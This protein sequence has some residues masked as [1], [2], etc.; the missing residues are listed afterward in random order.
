MTTLR[1][2]TGFFSA[3]LCLLMAACTGLGDD[4][5]P[6][7][8]SA[9]AYDP[10]SRKLTWTASGDDGD[11]GRGALADI[12]AVFDPLDVDQGSFKPENLGETV[13]FS[14]PPGAGFA[15]TPREFLVPRLSL[16][17]PPFVMLAQRDEV[18]NVGP[19]VIPASTASN[20]DDS[21][22][23]DLI[24][25]ACG[26]TDLTGP[27]SFA[28]GEMNGLTGEDLAVGDPSNNRVLVFY[29]EQLRPFDLL[30]KDRFCEPDAILDGSIIGA[31]FGT[32]VAVGDVDG[33]RADELFVSAPEFDRNDGL[34]QRG[35]IFVFRM[36]GAVART[37]DFFTVNTGP[38]EGFIAQVKTVEPPYVRL[39]RRFTESIASNREQQWSYYGSP[40]LLSGTDA[41]S[42]SDSL[43]HVVNDRLLD[44]VEQNW[45]FAITTGPNAGFA[46]RIRLIDDVVADV[47]RIVECDDKVRTS[48]T[49]S[50]A[51]GQGWA[52]YPEA[53]KGRTFTSV[54][55]NPFVVM[56]GIQNQLRM[57]ALDGSAGTEFP[58]LTIVGPPATTGTLPFGFGGAMTASG[59]LNGDGYGDLV[60]GVPGLDTV[61]WA[62]RDVPMEERGGVLVFL[63]DPKFTGLTGTVPYSVSGG[64]RDLSKL[65]AKPEIT[66]LGS[67]A[68]DRLG[69]A[70]SAARRLSENGATPAAED[71]QVP[72]FAL[73]MGAPGAD[74]DA[75]TDAGKVYAFTVDRLMTGHDWRAP[76]ALSDT[77]YNFSD[78]D[79]SGG[80]VESDQ[81]HFE[82]WGAEESEELGGSLELRGDFNLD[83]V[84]DLAVY[85]SG[86]QGE[87]RIYLFM[88]SPYYSDPPSGYSVS[89]STTGGSTSYPVQTINA[90]NVDVNRRVD[91]DGDGRLEDFEDRCVYCILDLSQPSQFG[92]PQVTLL[93]G[94]AA[95]IQPDI[96]AGDF[97]PDGM[98]EIAFRAS[99]AS[100]DIQVV[101]NG[102]VAGLAPRVVPAGADTCEML[103]VIQALQRYE[104]PEDVRDAVR[105]AIDSPGCDLPARHRNWIVGRPLPQGGTSAGLDGNSGGL[106]AVVRNPDDGTVQ[107][108]LEPL[109][110]APSEF[111]RLAE[112]EPSSENENT[113]R[114][115]VVEEPDEYREFWGPVLATG[116]PSGSGYFTGT[117]SGFHAG[118]DLNGDGQPDFVFAADGDLEPL[119]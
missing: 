13:V 12:R 92:L 98:D 79:G 114:V 78:P 111:I 70:L 68:G 26:F 117:V 17:R 82:I 63:G 56:G 90:G 31:G 23:T 55:G 89:G 4:T 15:G 30:P 115:K 5:A 14:N 41:V 108:M 16:G 112:A 58:S 22:F 72:Y 44:G 3:A 93:G 66:F 38:Q 95:V 76:G 46:C 39:D 1:R 77:V 71:P 8:V 116:R 110:L 61:V 81:G 75:L 18:G 37:G 65:A 80:I 7:P 43:R 45:L 49:V 59:D 94:P 53:T 19:F 64:F 21:F 101:L 11:T 36:K 48:T 47:K 84:N 69:T 88:A 50:A 73:A 33:D 24:Q 105:S 107:V 87:G 86:P 83:S 67:G 103:S 10:V 85:A 104:Q 20:S 52:I 118:A 34:G 119:H 102:N 6:G 9:P 40:P 106:G 28:H 57:V 35:A 60:V 42:F 54:R 62:D 100:G 74:T 99:T 25:T 27:V 97:L 32:T 109:A 113:C 96:Q 2:H 51:S 29:G 91:L